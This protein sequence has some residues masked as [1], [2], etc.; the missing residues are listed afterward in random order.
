M[1][2][3]VSFAGKT[4]NLAGI[5]NQTI[6][7]SAAIDFN[8]LIVNKETGAVILAKNITVGGT[9][10]LTKG[11]VILGANNLT[12]GQNAVAGTFTVNNMIVAD[13]SGLV[14]RPFTSIGEYFFPI[15]ELTSNPAYSPIKVK[16]TSGTFSNAFVGVSVVDAIHPNNYSSQN[17]ISRYW[18]V[19]QTGI[20]SAVADI[21]A[22]YVPAE[23]LVPENT[24]AAGQLDGTFN[25]TT[26]PWKKVGTLANLTL[27]AADV[28]LT[29]DQNSV[30]TG[31]K[32][33]DFTVEA[34]GYGEFCQ[35]S[36]VS[37]NAVTLGGD[38]PYT[39]LWTPALPNAAVVTI[40]TATVGSTNYQLTVTDANG[41][42]AFD[43]N[44]PVKILPASVGGAISNSTQQICV[45]ALP[46]ALQL[47]DSVGSVLYWQKSLDS[48]FTTF[49]NL[50]NTTTTLS[51]VEIG[52][53]MQTTYVR[54]VIQN[55]TCEEKVSGYATISIKSTTWNGTSWSNSEA[56]NATTSAIFT[57]NYTTSAEGITACSCEVS[58]GAVLTISANSTITIQNNIVNNGSI[59][60]ESDGNLIQINDS[61]VNSGVILVKRDLQFRKIERKEYNY[62]IS[63]VEGGDLKTKVYRKTDGTPVNAPFTLYHTES[64]N[65]FYNSSGAY[66]AGRSLAVKEPAL[67]SGALATAFFEGK[68]FNG[69][70]AYN[71]S[72]SGPSLGYNLVGNPYPS[73]LDLN[74][75]YADNQTE[76]ESTFQF[77]DNT[78][79][80]IYE[81]QGSGYTGNAYAVFN[82]VAGERGT[83]LPAPGKEQQEVLVPR[84]PNNIVKVGQGFMVKAKG[85][86]KILNYRNY[87]R[88][89][90]N[91]GS[92]FYGK[93]SQED[94]YFLKMTA[95][96]GITSTIA[97]VYFAG[98]NNL[99]GTDDSA[100]IPSS[101]EVYSIVQGE[102]VAINGR[103]TFV[104][105]DNI[106]LGTRH[107]VGGDYTIALGD[108]E[109]IFANGQSIYLKDKQTNT[110]TNLN[111]GNYTFTA[112]AGASTGR[113][114][115]IYQSD[116]VLVTEST[117]KEELKVYRDGEDFV[118]KAQ[119]KKITGVE[120]YDMSGRLIFSQNANNT[121]VVV[122]GTS[123]SNG[124]YLL[125]I[126]QGT[127]VYTKKILK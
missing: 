6:G 14:L 98:G 35:G 62:L 50:P 95:P 87:G 123:L 20:T 116:V 43:N 70:I 44:S 111:A 85:T 114:E 15:G 27:S 55:G 5:S 94:R 63:P 46:V 74:V 103:S 99:F 109:G 125:K 17:Y 110:I 107:F 42:G 60:V 89:A 38:A 39:Y 12:L 72:Y 119:T 19:K 36:T 108:Q 45:G 92:V 49:E 10:T 25:I 33:G 127:E 52:P 26:N 121:K 34:Y 91:E 66:I 102:K 122:N 76:I 69:K 24:L 30:F 118:V 124:T 53:V 29:Q 61:A 47:G 93:Q 77:W 117:F 71:L 13:G 3:P 18:N 112:S 120:V 32:G 37:M 65:K 2:Q 22:N 40:P 105:T 31:I 9:L 21:T 78:A 16:I 68:P 106:P 4:I 79:N 96:S 126:N 57:G 67:N 56:P 84:T 8:D 7:G 58:S 101:D 75:L 51:S 1:N 28:T 104:N 115:I 97:M 54:A 81:Q 64:N 73:N 48:N 41:F 90:V 23:V 83:G 88:T 59:V 86:G 82:A 80:A 11:N 100:A 113:F